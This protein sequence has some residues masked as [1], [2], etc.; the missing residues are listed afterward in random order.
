MLGGSAANFAVHANSLNKA[1]PISAAPA[2]PVTGAAAGGAAEALTGTRDDGGKTTEMTPSPPYLH[3]TC[4]LHTSVAND[5][6]GQFVRRKLDE[7]G[8]EWSQTRA[9]EHQ[10]GR[11]WNWILALEFAMHAP[12]LSLYACRVWGY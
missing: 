7:H 9:R 6:M 3:Q 1:Q 5:E 12:V 4:V 10:V 8:V 2:P 11:D